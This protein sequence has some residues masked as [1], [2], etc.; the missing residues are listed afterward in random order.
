MAANRTK[1]IEYALPMLT[2]SYNDGTAWEAS[3]TIDTVIYIPETTSRVFRSVLL[4][5]TCNDTITVAGPDLTARG[6]SLSCNGGVNWTD[7]TLSNTLADTGENMSYIWMADMT[8]EF[9]SRFGTAA[10][11]IARMRV[12]NDYSSAS[13]YTNV[14][15][16]LYIT[17][18]YDDTAHSTRCKTVRIPI[19]SNAGR[20]TTSLAEIGSNQVPQLTTFLPES[21]IVYRQIYFELWSNTQPGST[22]N[23]SL[24]LNLDSE[25][26]NVFGPIANTLQSPILTKYIWIRNDIN[27][28][29]THAIKARST[30]ATNMFAHIGGNLI[31]NYEYNHQNSTR[32]LNSLVVGL[33]S[34]SYNLQRITSMDQLSYP[35]LI[36][37][38][39]PLTLKQ[40]SVQLSFS[41]ATTNTSIFLA[42][43]SQAFREYTPT[44]QTAQAGGHLITQRI[45][46]GSILGLANPLV[47][48][49]NCF[50]VYVYSSTLGRFGSVSSIMFLNYESNKYSGIYDSGDGCHNHTLYYCIFDHQRNAANEHIVSQSRIPSIIESN[51]YLND[52]SFICDLNFSASTN[53]TACLAEYGSGTLMSGIVQLDSYTNCIFPNER[54]PFRAY[55]SDINNK[56]QKRPQALRP[57]T[58]DIELPRTYRV[59]SS[60]S[61]AKSLTQIITYNSLVYPISGVISGYTGDGSGILVKMNYDEE[62]YLYASGYSNVSG[63]YSIINYDPYSPTIY[64]MVRQDSTHVGRSDTGTAI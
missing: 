37:E 1:T 51:Y 62:S 58:F 3:G 7:S 64:T 43:G 10:S 48:G 39:G 15:G 46:S 11:G 53:S 38:P 22:T 47:S 61:S 5:V 31:V 8:D 23:T 45:D 6:I 35:L 59:M 16:K 17:Y 30:G 25:A 28:S 21:G 52:V 12:Y 32:I 20:L 50:N 19:E 27:P 57:N 36:N 41:T 49:F 13:T 18:D 40:S 4:E 24:A 54:M 29:G 42:A 9:T 33:G 55:F 63:V 34:T 60:A 14:A 2:G 44:T 56:F 26:E